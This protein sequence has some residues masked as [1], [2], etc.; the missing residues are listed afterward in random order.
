MLYSNIE[1][2]IELDFLFLLQYCFYKFIRTRPKFN[3]HGDLN[4]SL[5]GVEIKNIL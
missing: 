2:S 5:I 4:F 3:P 1:L